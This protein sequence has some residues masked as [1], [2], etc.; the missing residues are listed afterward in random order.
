MTNDNLEYI[1]MT[2][3]EK[4]TPLEW[5]AII[6]FSILM[7]LTLNFPFA[8]LFTMIFFIVVLIYDQKKRNIKEFN[9]VGTISI[10]IMFLFY[11]IDFL[12]TY[13]AVR[14]LKIARETN[15][16]ILRSWE[17]L[18]YYHA[19]VFRV[20]FF[21]MFLFIPLLILVNSK[22]NKK[23]IFSY[24]LIL[25]YLSTWIIVL[26]NNFWVIFEYYL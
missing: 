21:T 25:Y 5:F 14:Y 24:L 16:F 26:I 18:G 22:D 10:I 4:T 1:S 17:V 11:S 12:Q 7:L 13:L 9:H 2:S 19:E 3:S 15:P 23:M 8:F 20:T 6:M